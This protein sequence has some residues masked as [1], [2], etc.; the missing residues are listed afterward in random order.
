[1]PLGV[2]L[3]NESQ[4]DEMCKVL[5]ELSKYIPAKS[6]TVTHYLPDGEEL[7]LDEVDCKQYPILT[8][9]DQFSVA[10]YR[11][12]QSVRTNDDS[13]VGRLKGFVPAIEDWHARLTLVKVKDNFYY[14]HITTRFLCLN[15]Y[16]NYKLCMK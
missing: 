14:I 15:I 3:H 2:Q 1:M 9:G 4:V 7:T 6:C 12:A 5:D 16:S 13:T 11:T 8:G 10:R